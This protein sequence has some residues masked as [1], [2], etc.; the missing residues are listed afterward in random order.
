MIPFFSFL[1]F[2][3]LLISDCARSS[4]MHGLFSSCGEQ[5]TL[6]QH[7]G[8]S[9]CRAQALGYTGFSSYSS[10]ALEFGLSS[11]GSRA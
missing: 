7:G 9:C 5:E 10:R 8:F 11:C 1:M 2:I 6:F 3:Y 4:L